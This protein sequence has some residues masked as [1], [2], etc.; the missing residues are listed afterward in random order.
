MKAVRPNPVKLALA[1]IVSSYVISTGEQLAELN[2]SDSGIVAQ[3][4]IVFVFECGVV[5]GIYYRKSWVRWIYAA[6]IAIW[7]I[8]LTT[9]HL[10]GRTVFHG[11]DLLLLALNVAFSVISL[12][13]LFQR[14]SNEWF[15]KQISSTQ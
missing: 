9:L 11:K 12:I 1:L 4:I 2:L 6:T 7:L 5:F 8:S 10:F 14:E 15:R 3:I 13:L